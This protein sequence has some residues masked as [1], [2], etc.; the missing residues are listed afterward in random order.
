MDR[1]IITEKLRN[2][3]VK[4]L[5]HEDFEITD[6]LSAKDVS[7]WDSL[8]HMLIVDAVEK[9]FSIQFKFRE[10]NKMKN[11]GDMID[12]ISTKVLA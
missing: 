9:D 8:S 11:L 5:E 12:L 1:N 7:G 6:E 4:T 3:L 2:I 10:L